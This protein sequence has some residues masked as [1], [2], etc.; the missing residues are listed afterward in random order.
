M[1]ASFYTFGCKLNQYE[2]E[3]LASSFRSRGFSVGAAG[4]EQPSGSGF[5]AAEPSTAEPAADIYI[6]NTCTVTSKSEQKARRLIRGLSRR[7]PDSLLVV[8]GCY[9]QM[10]AGEIAELGENILVVPQEAKDRLLEAPEL[11][12]QAGGAPGKNKVLLEAHLRSSAA[13][14]PAAGGS[15]RYRV[16]DFSFHSR[17]FLKIQ[18][19]CD[20][21]CAYCRV[22]LA[23]GGAVSAAPE[24]L[25]E[26][27]QAFERAG[28]RELVLTGVNISAYRSGPTGLRELLAQFLKRSR[29]LRLRLSSLEPETV[30]DELAEILADRRICAHFHLPVQSGSDAMLAGMR[31]RYRA[32]QVVLA[33]ERLRRAKSEAFLAA[34]VITGFPGETEADFGRTRALVENLRFSRLHVFPFS[35]RP[36][37]AAEKMGGRVPERIRD[38]RARELRSLSSRLYRDYAGLWRGREVEVVLEKEHQGHWRGVSGNY[39]KVE[40]S[41]ST[42]P[43]AQADRG[44]LRPGLLVRVRIDELGEPGEPGEPCRGTFL[45]RL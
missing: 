19:G 13:P 38:D 21:S 20:G 25:L 12:V 8:T 32:G 34:D 43:T 37:T 27:L 23:R 14:G 7:H 26:R 16:A 31:R 33:V 17:A 4:A 11:L 9:A 24:T 44:V 5:G 45:A 30:T 6:I 10:G 29:N 3:A 42:V 1:R 36:G 18:D 35:P 22:P 41:G 2:T 28:Y 40:L 39:L 15:F